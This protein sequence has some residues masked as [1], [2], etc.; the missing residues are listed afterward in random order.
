MILCENVHMT[1]LRFAYGFQ[2]VP[3]S[4][5]IHTTLFLVSNRPFRN[6]TVFAF[7]T[8]CRSAATGLKMS[9][10]ETAPNLT[11]TAQHSST[12]SGKNSWVT[13][14]DW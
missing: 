5:L 13:S 6:G 3:I 7:S 9:E 10:D 8:A 2:L 11:K 1:L 14:L 4:F 12:A